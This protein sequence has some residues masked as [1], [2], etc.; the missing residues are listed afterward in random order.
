M[1]A[2]EQRRARLA[3]VLA[4]VDDGSVE[5]E[6][7]AAL[8]ELLELGLQSGRLRAVYGP[9]GEQAAL[10]LYRRLPRGRELGE[11]ARE[12]SS[13]LGALEGRALEKVSVQALGPCAHVVTVAAEGLELSI[14]LD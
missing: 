8:G 7:A 10:T 3:D 1:L 5:G 6:D 11:A 9:E 4:A 2:D 14:R 13:A 12:V